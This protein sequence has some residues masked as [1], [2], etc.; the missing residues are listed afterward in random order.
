MDEKVFTISSLVTIFE[1]FEALCWK[2][3]KTSILP[4]YQLEL[5]GLDKP[6]KIAYNKPESNARFSEIL[7]F[8]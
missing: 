3:I 7:H 1:Y 2:D 6:Q 4:D 5:T 8:H